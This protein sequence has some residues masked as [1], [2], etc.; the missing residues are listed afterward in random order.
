MF[1]ASHSTTAQV[2]RESVWSLWQDVGKWSQWDQGLESSRLLDSFEEGGKASL[3]PKGGKALEITF[4]KVVNNK[5]F[6]D[7]ADVGFATINTNHIMQDY[8]GKIKIT[9]QITITPRG[10]EAQKIVG[11]RLWPNISQGLPNSVEN[12]AELA[13]D[14]YEAALKEDAP[15]PAKKKRV[16]EEEKKEKKIQK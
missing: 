12:L 10:E 13:Q 2:S 9:H 16:R 3:V 1:I 14:I 6:S 4:S 5:Q 11:E 7:E 8:R 15:P